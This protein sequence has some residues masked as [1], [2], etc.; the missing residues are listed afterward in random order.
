MAR[1]SLLQ[2]LL[3][4]QFRQSGPEP[5]EFHMNTDIDT[6][7]RKQFNGEVKGDVPSR[8]I[9]LR[10]ALAVGCGLLLPA[11]LFGCDS[12]KATNSAGA[13]P[14]PPT[15]KDSTGADSSPAPSADAAAP[16][17]TAKVSQASVQYQ[18]QPKGA[19]HCGNCVNFIAESNTCK[20][21]DGQISPDGWCTL[22]AQK[23]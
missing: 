18:T 16:A 22:W 1:S 6:G 9:V 8:R 14:E 21:V 17:A 20:L 13:A 23:A 7:N 11:A 5:K 19:Q 15:S 4:W 10:G 3:N 2:R 12:K